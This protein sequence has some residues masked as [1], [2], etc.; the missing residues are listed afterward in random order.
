MVAVVALLL[1]GC[2]ATGVATPSATTSAT[3]GPAAERWIAY[4]AFSANSRSVRLTRSN[5]SDDHALVSSPLGQVTHPDWSPDGARIVFTVDDKELWV[6]DVDGS[7]LKQLPVTCG[8]DCYLL[9]GA[10]WSPDG[11]SIAYAHIVLPDGGLPT[12]TIERLDLASGDVS[13]LYT[14]PEPLEIMLEVRWAPSGDAIVVDLSRYPSVESDVMSG[15]AIA[16]VELGASNP[17]ARVLTDW[18]LFATY[19]DWSPDGSTIVFSTYDLGA[20]DAGDLADPAVA[21]DLYTVAP[22]GTRLTRLTHNSVGGS[23][24]RNATASGPLSTQPSWS[25]DGSSIVFVQV[26]G[27]VWPGWQL[28]AIDP[29]GSKLRPLV[30][31]EFVQ[32][33]HPRERPGT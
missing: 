16:V 7:G 6:V 17:V 33:T 10:A 5:G 26:D 8:P 3:A 14:S 1:G 31:E 13:V 25:A 15:S 32:G 28:A 18:S 23:L 30:G 20:R 24:I 11:K 29:D 4:Q 27:A 2:A 9:D 21:S 19:P 12:S 22:D